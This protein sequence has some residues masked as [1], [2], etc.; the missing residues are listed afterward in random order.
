[1]RI[2]E[3]LP[4]LLAA[5]EQTV[6]TDVELQLRSVTTGERERRKVAM[7]REN[8]RRLMSNDHEPDGAPMSDHLGAA[9]VGADLLQLRSLLDQRFAYRH[10]PE[11]D[12]DALFAAARQQLGSGDVK[13]AQFAGE[14]QRLLA[15]FADG[16]AGV[17][18]SA[19]FAAPGFLPCLIEET[20]G[21]CVAF[22]ADRTAF[23]DPNHPFVLAIDGEPI[24]KWL[25]AAGVLVAPGSAEYRRYHAV[26]LLRWLQQLRVLHGVATRPVVEVTFGDAAGNPAPRTLELH[27][28]PPAYGT[29]PRRDSRIL[30]GNLGYL[31]L[32]DT[33]DD[34]AELDAIDARMADFKA[35]RGLIVDV[36]GSG[37]GSRQAL[38]RLFPYL[39]AAQDPPRVAGIAAFRLTKGTDDPNDAQGY[40]ADQG[41]YP[42]NWSGWSDAART[43]IIAASRRFKPEWTPPAGQFSALHYFV[44]QRSDNGKAYHYE[45]PVVVLLDGGSCGAADTLLGACKGWH[46]VTLIGSSSS[47]SGARPQFYRLQA[48]GL[49][50][51]L[52]SMAS[53]RAD[54]HL[55]A[56]CGIAPDVLVLPA[57]EDLLGRGDRA[58]QAAQQQLLR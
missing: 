10:R 9:S 25:D 47:G 24:A 23:V 56:G 18:D 57:P 16:D 22:A 43:A 21:G 52:A 35:T 49:A 28:R 58:L 50:L 40:L 15:A 27:P 20:A 33:S 55:C 6:G 17:A 42:A 8:R 7:T 34:D 54:G 31:R 51:R 46:D 2:N 37:G 13:P 5:M 12:I 44:L 11:V 41:L 4:A 19:G 30:D 48:S 45:R 39:L 32:A 14:V 3:D 1:K 53:Y 26:R 38:R 29:W 36:R